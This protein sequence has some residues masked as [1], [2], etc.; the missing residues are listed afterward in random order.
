MTICR[1]TKNINLDRGEKFI[2][3]YGNIND[4]FCDEDM[5][6]GNIDFMLWRY[7]HRQQYKRI[8][9]FQGS[10]MIYFF[11][12]ESLRLCLPEQKL[13]GNN[14]VKEESTPSG[15]LISGPLGNIMLLN[16]SSETGNP[17]YPVRPVRSMSYIG[18]LQILD[19]IMLENI[20]TVI[21]F[22]N[23][24]DISPQNFGQEAF[25]LFQSQLKDWSQTRDRTMN[26]CVFIFQTPGLEKIKEVIETNKLTFLTNFIWFKE[27]FDNPNNLLPVG[28][29]DIDEINNLV[30]HF[31]L[32]HKLK[33]D[34]HLL[35]NIVEFLARQEI[36]L[37]SWYNKF[38]AIGSNA[39]LNKEMLDKWNRENFMKNSSDFLI[40]NLGK[41]FSISDLTGNLFTVQNQ[42]ESISQ[43]INRLEL[44]YHR[45]NKKK[46]LM[47]FFVGSSGVG[48]TFTV[49]LLASS[50]KSIG[51][52][53][54]PLRMAEFQEKESIINLTGNGSGEEPR[55]FQALRRSKNRL[56]IL[57]DEIEKAHPNILKSLS[58]LLEEG[59]LSWS[60]GDGDFRNC[61][62][63]FT[64]GTQMKKV[65]E[66][67]QKWLVLGNKI[68]DLEYQNSVKDILLE[69][70]VAPEIGRAVDLFLVYNPLT[71]E[72]IMKIAQQE[73]EALAC[74]YDL[75]VLYTDPEFL[76]DIARRT[77][78]SN[79][80]AGS[81]QGYL[82]GKI[83][84]LLSNYQKKFPR[85]K[86]VIIENNREGL[87]V[88]PVNSEKL[89]DKIAVLEKALDIF[90]KA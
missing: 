47:F 52:E 39:I 29:P 16:D 44:W 88:V 17:V 80:G 58:Q 89:P 55:L 6:F 24:E 34:W 32:L 75:E 86:Q 38:Q 81:F 22:N 5:V 41:E 59:F 18:A 74:E 63:C 35:E 2:L 33:V 46:P 4:D 77:A 25:N 15:Q 62:I 71:A 79:Y 8:I 56:L 30:H 82:S 57:F 20:P 64:S 78:G 10:K 7:F 49:K 19:T 73:I 14:I 84:N 70:G 50:L 40:E 72:A 36:N 26:K 43:I 60:R 42:D 23:A 21:I 28:F 3:L 87:Q 68:E 31:R 27:K 48:K 9:F 11:D 90:E 66:E 67:K 13:N 65:V 54:F 12:Q 69:G 83:G 45:K 1:L 53:Y 61:I 51:Y 76:V 37:K 85:L